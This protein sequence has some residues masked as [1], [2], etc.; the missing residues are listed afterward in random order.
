MIIS[1]SID[2][3]QHPVVLVY[4]HSLR[5]YGV[6][7]LVKVRIKAILEK[8]DMTV[9]NNSASLSYYLMV[10]PRNSDGCC[11][12]FVDMYYSIKYFRSKHARVTGQSILV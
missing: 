7:S 1:Y 3:A 8:H 2:K 12:N 4:T 5:L 9:L 6:T 11:F 10:L